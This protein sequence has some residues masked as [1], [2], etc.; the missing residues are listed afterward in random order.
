M[1]DAR[2][3]FIGLA[4]ILLWTAGL[5]ALLSI[6]LMAIPLY[7]VIPAM[8]AQ[9]FLYT[10]LFITAHDAMHGLVAPK[11]K[12][13]NQLIGTLCVILYALFSYKR[14]R[15]E[16]RQHHAHPGS[17]DDPDFHDGAHPGFAA[18]YVHFM[19][20]YVTWRQIAGMA[21]AFNLMAHV[22]KIPQ[23]NLI[24]F[25][26]APALLS[27][28]QLFY[29]GTYL[30]H[31]EPAGGYDNPHRAASNDFSV[32]WSFITCYHFGYHWE[33]HEFPQVPWWRLPTIRREAMKEKVFT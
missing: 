20:T 27:T 17:D 2:G 4:I 31:R 25:W 13:L 19:K 8:L 16:H 12:R 18:W 10:G 11:R 1:R 5:F 9:T 26:A 33:H 24:V 30:P 21:M 6:D 22:L 3:I 14:L 28:L 23:A 29:F 15:A 32:F 7:G